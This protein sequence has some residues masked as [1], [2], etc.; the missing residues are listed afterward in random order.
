[1]KSRTQENRQAAERAKIQDKDSVVVA[2]YVTEQLLFTSPPNPLSAS[3]EGGH[4][5]GQSTITYHVTT[6][7]DSVAQV[8]AKK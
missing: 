1:V 7:R 4:A 8:F 6:T 5:Q 3:R 2:K